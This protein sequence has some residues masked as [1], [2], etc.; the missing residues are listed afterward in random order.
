MSQPSS[1]ARIV[2]FGSYQCDLHARE[3]HKN[4]IKVKLADQPFRLLA[5]LVERPGEVVTRQELRAY[6]WSESGFGDFDD[7]LNTAINKLRAALDDNAENPRFVETLPRRGYRFLGNVETQVSNGNGAGL[8]PLSVQTCVA[9]QAAVG[10]TRP[11]SGPKFVAHRILR[12]QLALLSC[13]GVAAFLFLIWWLTPLP[14]PQVTRINQ[15]TYNS[16]IDTPVK[17]FSD[18]ERVYYIERNGD[19]WNLMQVP[20]TGG[21]SHR[22]E[23]PERNAMVADLSPDRAKLLVISFEKRDGKNQFW[24]MPFQ[25]GPA[26]RIGDVIAGS[27]VF[28]PT[29]RGSYIRVIPRSGQ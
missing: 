23:F 20:A 15:I 2:R 21:E 22:F 8:A 10:E 13:V 12:L 6:L 19:H 14:A 7:G 9:S 26:V 28:L 24:L 5:M 4:G 27:A 11:T 25:G 1:L 16:R 18:G 17:P 29:A 3:L